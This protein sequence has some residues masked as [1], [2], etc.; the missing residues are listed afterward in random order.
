MAGGPGVVRVDRQLDEWG[1]RVVP[2]R[3]GHARHRRRWRFWHLGA[4]HYRRD[5]R[6]SRETVGYD[7][8]VL[9]HPGIGCGVRRC[10]PFSADG[11]AGSFVEQLLLQVAAP[12]LR[13]WKDVRR[14]TV[15]TSCPCRGGGPSA[16]HGATVP[17]SAGRTGAAIRVAAPVRR[18]SASDRPE[19]VSHAARNGADRQRTWPSA[20]RVPQR[21]S[22]HDLW[23]V[24][25]T[26][27]SSPTARVWASQPGFVSATQTATPPGQS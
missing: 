24:S 13:F 3:F 20:W 4:H 27:R 26:Q 12:V 25:T 23:R 17:P 1:G 19:G 15:G 6:P 10:R 18:F 14:P 8:T 21:S 5:G 7:P 11:S 22:G 9:L 16:H 2:W